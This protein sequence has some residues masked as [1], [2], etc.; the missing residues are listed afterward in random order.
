M[1]HDDPKKE[2]VKFARHTKSF[3]CRSRGKL[4]LSIAVERE[5]LLKEPQQVPV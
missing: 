1:Q 3:T 5:Q 4:S 2:I